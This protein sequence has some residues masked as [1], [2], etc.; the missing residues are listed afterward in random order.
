VFPSALYRLVAGREQH[1]YEGSRVTE[2]IRYQAK[3]CFDSNI[4]CAIHE[5]AFRAS[6]DYGI[7]FVRNFDNKAVLLNNDQVFLVPNPKPELL[8]RFVAGCIW[9][10]GVSLI[11]TDGIDLNLGDA[12]PLLRD[13][14]FNPTSNVFLPII[15][16]RRNF[17]SNGDSIRKFL[18]LPAKG[19]GAAE[20][21]WSFFVYGIEFRMQI[22]P[23]AD[24]VIP[25]VFIINEKNPIWC[26]NRPPEE[27]LEFPGVREVIVNM[28]RHD[29]T[30]K[31][32]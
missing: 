5:D 19:F 14:I 15:I 28:S 27:F 31:Q 26:I 23:N 25:P 12:E 10:R 1:A 8:V 24:Q 30:R 16:T 4:L 18:W 2:G 13:I 6:D 21:N 9:R 22:T 11:D 3:G 32:K 17:I 7:R 20:G 29:R